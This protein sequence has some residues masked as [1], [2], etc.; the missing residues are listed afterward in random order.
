[1]FEDVG[2]FEEASIYI[3]PP[4]VAK[5]SADEDEWGHF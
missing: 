3:E 1:M 4:P 5:D 2:D